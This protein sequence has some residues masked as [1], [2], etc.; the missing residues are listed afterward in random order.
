[1]EMAEC[2]LCGKLVP[3]TQLTYVKALR[4]D[5]CPVHTDDELYEIEAHGFHDDF[6]EIRSA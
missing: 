4:M 2:D 3:K 5:V 6:R 1:M